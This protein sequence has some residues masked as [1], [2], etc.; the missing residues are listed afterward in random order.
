[1]DCFNIL[2][3]LFLFCFMQVSPF[4]TMTTL[5]CWTRH[6]SVFS[7]GI[8]VTPNSVNPIADARLFL[9]V[10]NNPVVVTLVVVVWLL[11]IMLLIWARRSDKNELRKV[12]KKY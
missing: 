5:H 7:G 10:F 6:L 1:M 2:G 9:N 11:Y 12:I 4:T 3:L 8:F